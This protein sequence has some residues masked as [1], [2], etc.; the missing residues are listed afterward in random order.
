M[1]ALTPFIGQ[2]DEAKQREIIEK[3]A[4][5]YFGRKMA[6]E[7]GENPAALKDLHISGNQLSTILQ[8]IVKIL[9]AK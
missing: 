6:H 5:E 7:D 4:D 3:K 8:E 2:L 9:K 1:A